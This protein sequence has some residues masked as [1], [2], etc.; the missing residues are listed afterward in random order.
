MSLKA[1]ICTQCGGK[2]EVDDSKEAGICPFCGTAFITEKVIN[3]YVT[4]NNFAGATINVQGGV[5]TE[6]LYKIARRAIYANNRDDVLKYYG[7]IRERNPD[8]WEST[9]FYA[10][11]DNTENF[12]K[13]FGITEDLILKLVP[14]EQSE[15][16]SLM[17]TLLQNAK[18]TFDKK[19]LFPFKNQELFYNFIIKLFDERNKTVVDCAGDL[20]KFLDWENKEKIYHTIFSSLWD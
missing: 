10:L 13:Y 16:L 6:N 1:A 20:V 12:D 19:S 18:F 11:F 8:D 17:F 4:Q 15:A 14:E 5:D 7:Q 2:I 9:F 3:Q